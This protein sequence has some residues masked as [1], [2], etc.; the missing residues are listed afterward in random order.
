MKQKLKKKHYKKHIWEEKTGHTI[1]QSGT[2][3]AENSQKVITNKRKQQ[4]RGTGTE[5]NHQKWDGSVDLS[6]FS[7]LYL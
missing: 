6:G 5:Q 1:G 4:A 2:R 3:A 7:S